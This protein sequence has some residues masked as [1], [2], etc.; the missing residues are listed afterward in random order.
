MSTKTAS[1][2]K[3][4]H[5]T[6]LAHTFN[7]N[8]FQSI[9]EEMNGRGDSTSEFE[10]RMKTELSCNEDGSFKPRQCTPDGT[11]CW[12]VNDRGDEIKGTRVNEVVG[13]ANLPKCGQWSFF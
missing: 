1:F 12:C 10:E 3:L 7:R 4:Q 11:S 13:E 2:N 6:L 5:I 9:K 8:L